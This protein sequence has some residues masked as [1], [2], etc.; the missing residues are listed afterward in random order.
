MLKGEIAG[1]VSGDDKDHS[2]TKTQNVEETIVEVLGLELQG[3][4]PPGHRPSAAQSQIPSDS[5]GECRCHRERCALFM[6]VELYRPF[7]QNVGSRVVPAYAWTEEIIG[8]YVENDVPG[9]SQIIIL[10]Q[11]D[12]L[13]FK[14]R[15]SKGEGYTWEEAMRFGKNSLVLPLG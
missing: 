6:E 4:S 8:D 5:E 10:N 13:L 7:H 9:L 12:C 14:G 11:K 1:T 15:Q 2:P 3:C